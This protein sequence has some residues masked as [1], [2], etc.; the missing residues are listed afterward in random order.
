MEDGPMGERPA[1]EDAPRPKAKLVTPALDPLGVVE[2][3]SYIDELRNE[4]VRAEDAITKKLGHRSAAD[5]V[6]RRP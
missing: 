6:F 4:I 5:S 1:D 2:L 3:Q